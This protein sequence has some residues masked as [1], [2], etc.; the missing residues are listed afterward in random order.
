MRNLIIQREKVFT[1][2]LMN[3]NCILNMEPT[4]YNDEYCYFYTNMCG[5]VYQHD[6]PEPI[7]FDPL[8]SQYPIKN[9]EKIVLPIKESRCTLFIASG[10]YFSNQLIIEPGNCDVFCFI[11]TQYIFKNLMLASIGKKTAIQKI[12]LVQL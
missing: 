2:S 4:I 11:K 12:I 9:G 1:G 3:Y 5:S 10:S 8:V 6:W 7:H